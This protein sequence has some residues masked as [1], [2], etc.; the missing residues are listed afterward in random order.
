M[1]S[2][3]CLINHI[4]FST[5]SRR[6]TLVLD[7]RRELLTYCCGIIKGMNCFTQRIN[8]VEDHMH[9]L[10]G[11]HPTVSVATFVKRFKLSSGNWIREHGGFPRFD[12]W[13]E[14]YGAFS[15]SWEERNHLIEYIKTQDD[16]HKNENSLDEFRRLV[17]Q[18]GLELDSHDEDQDV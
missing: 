18:A 11:F 5:K 2:Y 8:C 9:I 14:K 1:S 10:V 15:V 3:T 13:Q 6:P 16:H 17:A 7:H 12:H 4:V